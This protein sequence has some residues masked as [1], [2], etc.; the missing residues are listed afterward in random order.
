MQKKV[1]EINIQKNFSGNSNA[2]RI[3]RT[4]QMGLFEEVGS[5]RIQVKEIR[6]GGTR[7]LKAPKNA[8]MAQLLETG[9]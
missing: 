3:E 5:C 6:G 9:K 4:F 8:T 1:T 7:H 2:L